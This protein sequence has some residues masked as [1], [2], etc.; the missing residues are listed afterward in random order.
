M[1][2][3]DNYN[4]FDHSTQEIL[5]TDYDNFLFLYSCKQHEEKINAKGQTERDVE[6]LK[7]E[8][9]EKRAS[10]GVRAKESINMYMNTLGANKKF[11]KFVHVIQQQL[12]S[13]K[14]DE[15]K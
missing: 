2:K 5:D 10:V 7:A 13:E 11:V 15:A 12:L 8:E 14:E 9:L 3:I 1:E 4:P 6:S